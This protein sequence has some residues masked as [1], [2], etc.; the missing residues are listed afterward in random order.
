V[1]AL[2]AALTVAGF[3]T[4]G[5]AF[6][7][8]QRRARARGPAKDAGKRG[9]TSDEPAVRIDGF[10][11]DL[12]DVVL[13]AH[14]DEAWLAGALLLRERAAHADEHGDV[15]RTIAVLFIAP[16][17]GGDRAIY[18]RGAPEPSLDWLSPVPSD[19]LTVGRE[20]P[21]AIEHAGER[22]ERVRRLPLSIERAGTGAPDLGSEVIVAEYE[23]GAGAKLLVV[24]GSSAIKVWHGRRLVAGMYDVLPGSC[25]RARVAS[26]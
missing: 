11:C 6:W 10:P 4:G 24:I 17:R 18:A 15:L 3:A 22:F 26:E 5:V 12:G 20:P 19:A 25:P 2:L 23:G 8:V 21:S 16:D 14:G 7:I 9:A 13:L 1:I